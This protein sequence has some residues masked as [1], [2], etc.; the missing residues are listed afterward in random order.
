MVWVKETATAANETLVI[1]WPKAWQIETGI[2]S[3]MR[4]PSIGCMKMIAISAPFLTESI[5]G[6]S[7]LQTKAFLATTHLDKDTKSRQT[8]GAIQT[9][10]GCN[11]RQFKPSHKH[12]MND[13]LDLNSSSHVL[14]Q[15]ETGFLSRCSS[16]QYTILLTALLGMP[17][18]QETEQYAT[19][20]AKWI[21]DTKLQKTIN[22]NLAVATPS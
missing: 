5:K 6:C 9:K 22:T 14:H 1:T 17:T 13:Q 16:L 11:L 15:K 19:P 8:K 21:A 10:A 7:I 18:I 2:S 12:R 20:T 3:L 4:S